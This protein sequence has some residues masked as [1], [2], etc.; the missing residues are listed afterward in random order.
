MREKEVS[1]LQQEISSKVK[2]KMSE[3][4]HKYFLVEQLKL[5]K[6]E[7]GMERDDKEAIIVKYR[8]H[9]A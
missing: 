3:K 1:K 6:K 8:K 9:L 5:I 7:L 4:Q 2:A